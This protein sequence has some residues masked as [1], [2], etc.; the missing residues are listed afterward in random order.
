M[1]LLGF[2]LM[3][4][5]AESGSVK[6]YYQLHLTEELFK[7][8]ELELFHFVDSNV[9]KYGK[10]PSTTTINDFLSAY[11][12]QL[13]V[14]TEPPRFYKDKVYERFIANGIK[15]IT[16]QTKEIY[17]DHTQGPLE[18]LNFMATEA[19]RL[20]ISKN[21]G[22]LIDFRESHDIIK[23]DYNEKFKGGDNYGIQTGWP[24]LDEMSGGL[25]GGDVIVY[26]GRPGMGKTWMLLYSAH[27][28][29]FHQKKPVMFVSM[30]MVPLLIMQRLASM[31]THYS[32]T[33]LKKAELS[34]KAYNNMLK[35][36]KQVGTEEHPFWVVDGNLTTKI[37]D[38]FMLANILQPEA[39]YVDGAYMVKTND[40][41]VNA[42]RWDRIAY[43]VEG[44][45][46][47]IATELHIP[48]SATYQLTRDSIKKTKK[49]GDRLGLEDIYGGDSIGQIAS[50]VMGLMQHDTV[51]TIN[52]RRVDI[53]KGRGGEIG[54][55]DINW[56]FDFMNF[57]QYIP[58][59]PEDLQF[60]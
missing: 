54:G 3:A 56:M 28:A 44:L 13:P 33:K 60:I 53:M 30:E 46:S 16:A 38:I 14:A 52:R 51:E 20:A 2:D 41:R 23:A 22:K 42:N 1:S 5:L 57:D 29:W 24:Y 12:E 6:E 35:G 21:S 25:V 19:S 9:R 45:K 58:E 40:R 50:L 8:S 36:L 4:S 43:V 7:P 31:H 49:E 55:Y 48:V 47:N 27:H 17:E 15:Q 10:I 39:I 37:E 32:L 59:K 34:T 11:E 18:A 26:L